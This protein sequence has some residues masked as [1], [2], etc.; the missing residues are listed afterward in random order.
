MHFIG[1]NWEMIKEIIH[2]EYALTETTYK[3]WIEPLQFCEAKDDIV[4]IQIPA[5]QAHAMKYISNKYSDCFKITI[6]E[7]MAHNYD[8]IFVLGKD[9]PGEFKLI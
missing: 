9:S 3:T 1:K 2:R 5:D 4:Y 8:V 6:S 7:V